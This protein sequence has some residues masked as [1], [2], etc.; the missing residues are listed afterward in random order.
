MALEN[1]DR[2][3]RTHFPAHPGEQRFFKDEKTTT[4]VVVQAVKKDTSQLVKCP[5]HMQKGARIL[6]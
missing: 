5:F 6:P 4:S 2:N 3:G 1:D